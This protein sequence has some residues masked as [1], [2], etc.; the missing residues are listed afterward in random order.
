MRRLA[1]PALVLSG[2]VIILFGILAYRSGLTIRYDTERTVHSPIFGSGGR[3]VYFLLR[4][5]SGIS[6][7][8]GIEFFT[9]PAKVLFLRDRF[10]LMAVD[11]V[12]KSVRILRG[13]DVPHEVAR[14]KNTGTGF[15][16][17]RLLSCG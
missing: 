17:F 12:K 5:S 10:N 2:F 8:P 16:V 15:S 4:T 7:G 11:V 3:D 6:W 9:P 14:A 1:F 13:W